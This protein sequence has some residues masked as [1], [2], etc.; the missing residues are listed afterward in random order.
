MRFRCR[1]DMQFGIIFLHDSV[2]PSLSEPPHGACVKQFGLKSNTLF[3]T[4]AGEALGAVEYDFNGSVA[5]FQE[6]KEQALKMFDIALS[7]PV[8]LDKLLEEQQTISEGATNREQKALKS[9]LT[10]ISSPQSSDVRPGSPPHGEKSP[11]NSP[12]PKSSSSSFKEVHE[13]QKEPSTRHSKLSVSAFLLGYAMPIP[14]QIRL[15]FGKRKK[16]QELLPPPPASSHLSPMREESYKAVTPADDDVDQ[17]L[18]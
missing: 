11:T 2:H 16:G 17:S 9:Q 5:S 18:K 15:P 13:K 8:G 1:E 14:P 7:K 4:F 6:T 12:K 10:R 3:A